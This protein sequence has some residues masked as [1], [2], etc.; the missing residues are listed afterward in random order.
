M[1]RP[2]EAV[3]IEAPE[4]A[5]TVNGRQLTATIRHHLEAGRI[6]VMLPPGV[7]VDAG[8][9]AIVRWVAGV[10]SHDIVWIAEKPSA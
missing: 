3:T 6:V 4:F 2:D 1:T 5:E 8:Q 7:T 10:P 9:D